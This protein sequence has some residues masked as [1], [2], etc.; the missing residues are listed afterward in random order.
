MSSPLHSPR[1]VPD[2]EQYENEGQTSIHR[3]TG[4]LGIGK[5]MISAGKTAAP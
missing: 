2:K 3:H 1:D 4:K 5:S